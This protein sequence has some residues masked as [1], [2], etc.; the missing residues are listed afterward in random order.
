MKS[1]RRTPPG[2]EHL[3]KLSDSISKIPRSSDRLCFHLSMGK[4]LQSRDGQESNPEP[5]VLFPGADSLALRGV[6][7]KPGNR[8]VR[9]RLGNHH[10][11][12]V[13]PVP[14][15]LRQRTPEPPLN[16]ASGQGDRHQPG[17]SPR[18][19]GGKGRK[20]GH[21]PA[22]PASTPPSANLL[23]SWLLSSGGAVGRTAP[24]LSAPRGGSPLC[25]EPHWARASAWRRWPSSPAASSRVRALQLPAECIPPPAATPAGAGSRFSSAETPGLR[26]RSPWP[27]RPRAEAPAPGAT[28]SGFQRGARASAFEELAGLRGTV[29]G[30][31]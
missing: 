9:R 8:S 16:S 6:A 2:A 1:R 15:P 26:A 7:C 17:G 22:A 31:C 5:A 18:S 10:S 25:R 29:W 28:Q 3:R 21:P 30:L 13:P 24:V 4:P 27:P 12:H 11:L 14:P 20:G 23:Q 19:V